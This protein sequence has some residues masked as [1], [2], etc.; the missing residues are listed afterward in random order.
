MLIL[1]TCRLDM[2]SLN[3]LPFGLDMS[4]TNLTLSFW[5]IAQMLLAL[6]CG[7]GGDMKGPASMPAFTHVAM[8]SVISSPWV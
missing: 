1:P 6:K 7:K 3:D 2:L 4:R 5:L 8:L